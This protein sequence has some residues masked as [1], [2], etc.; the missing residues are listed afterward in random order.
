M[1]DQ[2]MIPITQEAF[3]PYLGS[4]FSVRNIDVPLELKLVE[5]E[6]TA[7]GRPWPTSLRRP[8]TMIF[9]GPP[10]AILIEGLRVIAAPDGAFCELYLIPIMTHDA[11]TVGQQ[12]QAT[13]N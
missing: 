3:D 2:Q 13:V 9:A 4:V 1:T 5:I 7:K 11:A 8:F 12:Y 6:D 10:E